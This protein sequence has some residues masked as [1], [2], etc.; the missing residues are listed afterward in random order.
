MAGTTLYTQNVPLKNVFIKARNL[1]VFRLNKI[2][3]S[4]KE[5]RATNS[6]MTRGPIGVASTSDLKAKS[7]QNKHIYPRICSSE[8]ANF[9]TLLNIFATLRAYFSNADLSF[10]STRGFYEICL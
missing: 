1:T 8:R 5:K 3:K 4:I 10:L 9:L 7:S 6:K 2:T